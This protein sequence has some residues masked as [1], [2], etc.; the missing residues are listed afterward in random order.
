MQE[1]PADRR[2]WCAVES[3]SG[4]HVPDAGQV[5]ADLVRPAGADADFKQREFR[6]APQYAIFGVGGA[7]VFAGALSCECGGRDRV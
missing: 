2:R 4:Y 7:A 1:K 3:V 6:E 5:D